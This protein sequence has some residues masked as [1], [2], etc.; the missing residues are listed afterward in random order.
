[1]FSNKTPFIIA[2]VGQNHNGNLDLAR[3]YIKVFA[4]LGADAVKF[5]TYS[6]ETL[7]TKNVPD[8][9]GYKNINQLIKDI[10]LPREWQKDLKQYFNHLVHEFFPL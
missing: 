7:Y 10:E 6:S 8:F 3:E 9:A 4:G 1:M 5:Q 2:E